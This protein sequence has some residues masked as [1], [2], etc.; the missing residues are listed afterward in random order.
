MFFIFLSFSLQ[1]IFKFH[2][3]FQ[4]LA[5]HFW[6]RFIVQ[7][8]LEHHSS[9]KTSWDF[10]PTTWVKICDPFDPSD[11]RIRCDQLLG[12]QASTT[13]MGAAPGEWKMWSDWS[14]WTCNFQHK[15]NAIKGD[16][17]KVCINIYQEYGVQKNIMFSHLQQ[18]ADCLHAFFRR[19]KLPKS[20]MSGIPEA[21]KISTSRRF[22]FWSNTGAKLPTKMPAFFNFWVAA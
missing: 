3:T 14:H 20:E 16:N 15:K 19:L 12:S 7:P 22:R 4:S 5:S 11:G 1:F 13:P 17:K 18:P 10:L 9:R 8:L 6:V 21:S 2:V